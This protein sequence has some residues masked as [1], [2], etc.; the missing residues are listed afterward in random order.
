MLSTELVSNEAKLPHIARQDAGWEPLC[1]ETVS[2]VMFVDTSLGVIVSVEP[3]GSPAEPERILALCDVLQ[4]WMSLLCIYLLL[5]CCSSITHQ[6]LCLVTWFSPDVLF[7]PRPRRA[8]N[9]G[10]WGRWDLYPKNPAPPGVLDL[11]LIA[12]SYEGRPAF[13]KTQV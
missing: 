12:S 13:Y 2:N 7:G 8:P 4:K 6:E 5:F 9:V 10:Q 3:I 11:S 1:D